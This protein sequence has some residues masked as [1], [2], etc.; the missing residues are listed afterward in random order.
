MIDQRLNAQRSPATKYFALIS[1][2]LIIG[3]LAIV[4]LQ[5][6]HMVDFFH[7][8]QAVSG[9]IPLLKSPSSSS[10]TSSSSPSTTSSTSTP[11]STT[12]TPNNTSGGK[13][14]GS[15]SSPSA[16]VGGA[17]LSP[18][19]TFVSNHS[20]DLSNSPSPSQEQSTCN[21]SIG[22]TCTITFKNSSGIVKSLPVQTTDNNGAT[23]WTWDV[24][25]AGFT[26]GS[27]TITATAVLNGQTKS[28]TDK[29]MLQVGS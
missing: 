3:I 21:T 4:A 22:A 24:Q 9:K 17:P 10:G 18:Y 20:P 14:T 16:P 1:I 29:L 19:G 27:W 6:T 2:L 15:Y 13:D 26:T 11:Q 23:T 28:T 25:S 5:A 12:T 7:H 8:P